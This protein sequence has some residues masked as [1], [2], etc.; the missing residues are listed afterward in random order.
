[1]EYGTTT[2]YGSTTTLNQTLVTSHSQALTGFLTATVYHYRVHSTNAAGAQGISGDF[3]LTTLAAPA[4]VIS[5]V[6][7]GSITSSGATITWNTDQ[8][9]NSQVE[10]GTTTA[11][12]SMTTLNQTL[13]TSHSQALTGLLAT[14]TYHY[15]IHTTNA[16]GTQGISGDFTFTTLAAS[17]PVISNVVA[18]SVTSNGATITWSTD[19]ASNS[20][21]EYGTTT[22][23]GSM[24]SLNPTLVTSHSQALTG[25]LAGTVYHYRVHSTNAAGLQGISGDFTFTTRGKGH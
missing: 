9:S 10:Y 8:A 20:Q 19:Q 11:Y 18:G 13:V 14:T 21:V 15:R 12:G 24:T 2:A 23:Y 5:N 4:P 6:V 7:A 17:A 22:A 16:S 25:F 1:V 3:M